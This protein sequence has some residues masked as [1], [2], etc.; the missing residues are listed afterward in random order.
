MF[1]T[2]LLVALWF[3]KE[4]GTASFLKA[5]V[6]LGG[7][8]AALSSLEGLGLIELKNIYPYP[9]D[10]NWEGRSYGTFPSPLEASLAYGAIFVASL[11]F[12][13][14]WPKLV[15]ALALVALALTHSATGLLAA[16]AGSLVWAITFKKHK[17]ANGLFPAS[18]LQSKWGNFS[19]RILMWKK[20]LLLCSDHPLLFLTGMGF[21]QLVVDNSFLMFFVYGGVILAVAV[22][23]YFKTVL[24]FTTKIS[25][26]LLI[27]WFVSWVSLD[28]VGYWGIGRLCWV[29]MG[30]MIAQKGERSSSP[31]LPSEAT[32]PC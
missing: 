26:P 8:S 5:T 7:V 21:T 16:T 17:Q 20:W 4:S 11:M 15:S 10:I 28:S 30:L 32:T 27:V 19:T 12:P 24:R 13:G 14:R 6:I 31:H 25:L 18:W 22:L 23:Y 29:L 3:E 1:S 9:H 2:P